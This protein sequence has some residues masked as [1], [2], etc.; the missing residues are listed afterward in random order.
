MDEIQELLND[1]RTLKEEG[2]ENTMEFWRRI[3]GGADFSKLGFDTEE[4]L[5]S[6]IADNPY[7]N[8]I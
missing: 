4:D 7:V 5:K 2:P 3:K 8:I 1:L 6:W